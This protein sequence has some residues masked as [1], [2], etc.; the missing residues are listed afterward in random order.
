V[1]KATPGSSGADL[2]NLVNE[3]ALFA[4]RKNKSVVEMDD[5]EDARDKVL[6]G[7]ARTSLIIAEE[8]KKATAFHEAGHAL[9]HYFLPNADPLHKVTIVPRG[10]ALGLAMSLPEND[11]YSKS[12]GW[13]FA[14]LVITY[15][16]YA[17]EKIVYGQTTTGT[18]Q[19]LRQ[20]TDIARRMVCEWG[21][22]EEIDPIA[23]GQEEEPI[24]LGKEIARH[25]D[26]SED[27]AKKID[28]AIKS[29]LG[30]ALESAMEILTRERSKLNTLAETLIVRETLEDADIQSLLGIVPLRDPIQ[31]VGA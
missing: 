7:V 21:M 25:K 1:A 16:G 6:M 4:I 5:F 18:A 30:K 17:A 13:L 23:Y 9:L 3:A 8:E 15:G 14:R 24:F 31:V 26:Y 20:A 28:D 12:R 10:R 29:I 2:A 22:A 27:T 11:S 19:D